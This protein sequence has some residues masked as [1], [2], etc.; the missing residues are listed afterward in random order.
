MFENRNRTGAIVGV[1]LVLAGLF[2]LAGQFFSFDFGRILWPFFVIGFGGL[3]FVGML[4]SG[5]SSTSAPLAIPGSIIVTVGLILLFQNFFD[6]WEGWSYSWALIVAAVGIGM[7]IS[8]YWSGEEGMRA[9][10]WRVV[11]TGIILFLVFGAFF[12]LVLGFSRGRPVAG[13]VWPLAL[14]LVG[15]YLV[16]RRLLPGGNPN[17]MSGSMSASMPQSMPVPPSE[18]PASSP[19]EGK[20]NLPPQS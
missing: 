6:Y 4:L 17:R 16:V 20:D 1:L 14:I 10:G 8:G 9:R 7:V 2:F 12:E 5:R 3:F 13:I 18:P 11:R 15:A 19:D